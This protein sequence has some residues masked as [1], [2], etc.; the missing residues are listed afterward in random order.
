MQGIRPSVYVHALDPG[1]DAAQDR[2]GNRPGHARHLLGVALAELGR[3]EEAQQQLGRAKELFANCGATGMHAAV[4]QQQRLQGARSTRVRK[5]GGPL[6]QRELEIAELVAH[7]YTNRQI[8]A[9]LFM[10]PKTVEAHLSRIFTKLGVASRT[11]VASHLARHA[12][13]M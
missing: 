10:S 1:V 4:V 7:G 6:T 9:Q 8:A 13:E 5:D 2:I 3:R 12:G 11:A